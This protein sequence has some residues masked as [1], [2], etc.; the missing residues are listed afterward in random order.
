MPS[1][2]RKS[3]KF[4]RDAYNSAANPD[5]PS[6]PAMPV[7]SQGFKP[8][9]G[10]S[11]QFNQSYIPQQTPVQTHHVYAPPLPYLYPPSEPL[12]PQTQPYGFWSVPPTPI[13]PLTLQ[14]EYNVPLNP[15]IQPYNAPAYGQP[16]S[17]SSS[18]SSPST[19]QTYQQQLP[20]KENQFSFNQP[21][22]LPLRPAQPWTVSVLAGPFATCLA[23]PS[24]AR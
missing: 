20:Q 22:P 3:M 18:F 10:L 1:L 15:P 12:K 21:P 23:C 17:P 16:L 24:S 2:A 6:M 7:H 5:A 19:P 8:N 11:S 14:S 13:S 4:M 9:Q